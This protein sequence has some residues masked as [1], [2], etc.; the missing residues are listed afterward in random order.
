MNAIERPSGAHTMFATP[1]D[2]VDTAFAS[3]PSAFITNSCSSP[4]RLEMKATRLPSGD[5]RPSLSRPLLVS[6]FASPVTTVTSQMSLAVRLPG[7]SGM[8][9]VYRTR[10][11]SGDTC[12]SLTRCSDSRSVTVIGRPAAVAV[13]HRH[14]ATATTINAETAERTEKLLPMS[15]DTFRSR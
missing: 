3:D 12:G 13:E 8:P 6:A 5:Q 7:T 14:N 11:P 10:A 15:D 1:P 9:T 4:E 2:S